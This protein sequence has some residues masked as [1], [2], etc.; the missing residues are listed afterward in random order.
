MFSHDDIALIF[1]RFGERTNEEMRLSTLVLFSFSDYYNNEETIKEL[2]E[3]FV[4]TN[5]LKNIYLV[6]PP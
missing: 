4:R 1:K 5:L 3:Y 6:K 2:Y